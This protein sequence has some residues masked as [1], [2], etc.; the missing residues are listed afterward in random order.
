MWARGILLLDQPLYT[1]LLILLF[2]NSVIHSALQASGPRDS[3]FLHTLRT[4]HSVRTCQHT[5][6]RSGGQK[7]VPQ[8]PRD[9]GFAFAFEELQRNKLFLL[10]ICKKE[11]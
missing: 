1:L 3:A 5:V 6:Y 2:T 9:L 10:L 7:N 4:Y 8:L 11:K